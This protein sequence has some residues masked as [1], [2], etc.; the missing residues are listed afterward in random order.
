M[1]M[2]DI[3]TCLRC[4]HLIAF[5]QALIRCVHYGFVAWYRADSATGTISY[6]QTPQTKHPGTDV[7]DYGLSHSQSRRRAVN[8]PTSDLEPS[9]IMSDFT[10]E[11]NDD[12]VNVHTL[13]ITT[14][15][16][17]IIQHGKKPSHSGF[18]NTTAP[19]TIWTCRYDNMFSYYYKFP[20]QERTMCKSPVSGVPLRASGTAYPSQQ[21]DARAKNK[22]QKQ[23]VQHQ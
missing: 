8:D 18:D 3:L 22:K 11:T 6:K 9:C 15:T 12:N 1:W 5:R 13:S 2:T 16:S 17:S 4:N 19:L 23:G 20:Q 14:S 10:D 7:T 21:S